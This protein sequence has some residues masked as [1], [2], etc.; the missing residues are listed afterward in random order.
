MRA[1]G[2][3]IS[4]FHNNLSSATKL[5]GSFS[6]VC[7]LPHKSSTITVQSVFQTDLAQAQKRSDLKVK[8]YVFKTNSVELAFY[9][10]SV[11][12]NLNSSQLK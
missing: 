9:V 4:A 12:V 8:N 7:D 11:S 6:L 3:E 2:F 10:D 1:F 5:V